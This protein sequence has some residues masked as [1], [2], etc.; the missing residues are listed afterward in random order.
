MEY[1]PKKGHRKRPYKYLKNVRMTA[2]QGSRGQ[3][4]FL[5]H[6][7]ENAPALKF[8]TIDCKNELLKDER[9]D[10]KN[11][12]KYVDSVH[13]TARRYLRGKISPRCSIR[14]L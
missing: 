1:E 2:F 4:E 5:L 9:K 6:T 11:E 10:A 3:L 14:L 7:V 8:L 12:A 13:R